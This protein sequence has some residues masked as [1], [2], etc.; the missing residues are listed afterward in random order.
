MQRN[1]LS[2]GISFPKEL[3]EK[4]DKERQDIRRSKY[5]MRIIDRLYV[6]NEA[7]RKKSV[8]HSILEVQSP[9]STELHKGEI[10][11]IS[12]TSIP[13]NNKDIEDNNVICEATVCYKIFL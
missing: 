4:I 1:M 2:V 10:D 6:K 12:T 13:N 11:M 3:L 5:V 7:R 8:I 9:R